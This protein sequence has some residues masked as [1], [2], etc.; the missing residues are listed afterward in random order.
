MKG[1][2]IRQATGEHVQWPNDGRDHGGGQWRTSEYSGAQ[3]RRVS[4][5]QQV[6]VSPWDVGSGRIM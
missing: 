3:K 2:K 1:R 6:Q 5:F 4:E